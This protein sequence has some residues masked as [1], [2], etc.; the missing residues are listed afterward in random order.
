MVWKILTSNMRVTSKFT[1]F[2]Y[3][4]TYYAI[5]GSFPLTLGMYFGIGWFQDEYQIVTF[6]PWKVFLGVIVIFQLLAPICFAVYRYRVGNQG[7]WKAWWENLRWSP[8]F[9]A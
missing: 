7:F 6:D 8:F 5:A 2:G 3:V 4:F 9:S 1:I